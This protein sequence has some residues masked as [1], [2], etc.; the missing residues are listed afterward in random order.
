MPC[1]W[2]NQ[3]SEEI[4]L[5]ILNV[6]I[7]FKNSPKLFPAYKKYDIVIVENVSDQ[8]AISDEKESASQIQNKRRSYV[9]TE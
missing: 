5:C 2:A 9:S 1:D 8:S 4:L 6:K 3:L 7:D